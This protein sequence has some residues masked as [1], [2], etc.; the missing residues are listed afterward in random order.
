[1]DTGA[2]GFEVSLKT[3]FSN[4][5]ILKYSKEP[6]AVLS[7]RGVFFIV[8]NSFLFSAHMPYGRGKYL[9]QTV[10]FLQNWPSTKFILNFKKVIHSIHIN[11]ASCDM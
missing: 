11:L 7:G 5:F 8:L 1:M 2:I 3:T 10:F 6:V 9:N 4:A